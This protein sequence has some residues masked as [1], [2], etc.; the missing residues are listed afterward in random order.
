MLAIMEL[1]AGENEDDDEQGTSTEWI[2]LVDRGGLWHFTNEAFMFF[3]AIEEVIHTHLTVSAINELSSGSKGAIVEAII[4]S[5]DVAFFWCLACIEA[6]EEEKKE[7]HTRIIDLWVNIQGFSF[8]RSWMEMYKP[9]PPKMCPGGVAH[10]DRTPQNE[11]G[12]RPTTSGL[13]SPNPPSAPALPRTCCCLHTIHFFFLFFL[14]L[15]YIHIMFCTHPPL[16]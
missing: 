7:L 10:Q 11:Q 15:F 14:L 2:S 9:L 16:I 4:G 13:Q 1:V 5:D 3:C 8:V 6:E 12:W